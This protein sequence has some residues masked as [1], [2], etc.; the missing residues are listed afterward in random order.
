ML[1]VINAKSLFQLF[2][3]FSFLNS[4]AMNAYL[5]REKL[6]EVT[7]HENQS[8]AAKVRLTQ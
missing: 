8:Q 1:I 3:V 7:F 2:P 6:S 5:F 4:H